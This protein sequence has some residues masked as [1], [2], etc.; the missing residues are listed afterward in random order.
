MNILQAW[1]RRIFYTEVNPVIKLSCDRMLQVDDLEPLPTNTLKDTGNSLSF[2][3]AGKFIL[4]IVRVNRKSSLWGMFFTLFRVIFALSIPVLIKL[5]LTVIVGDE[6]QQSGI[7]NGVVYSFLFAI[8]TIFSGIVTNLCFYWD[9]V[10]FQAHQRLLDSL[11]YQQ[12][13][14]LKATVR[15]KYRSG[16]VI[17]TVGNDVQTI[18]KLG[19]LV[20]DTFYV[21]ILFIGVIVLL[22]N[23]LGLGTFAAV[24]TLL[25]FQPIAQQITKHFIN[26]DNNRAHLRELR[27]NLITQLLSGIRTVKLYDLAG[28]LNTKIR[29]VRDQEVQ[30][31]I[32]W[33]SKA[34]LSIVL[35]GSTTTLICLA[36][37]GT[38]LLLGQ[39]LDPTVLFPS[40]GLLMLLE[41]P[42]AQMPEILNTFSGVKAAGQRVLNFLK[43]DKNPSGLKPLSEPGAAV[44]VSL[45]QV[46]F[47][48]ADQEKLIL[49]GIDLTVKT[50]EAVAIVGSV[51]SGKSVLLRSLLEEDERLSGVIRWEGVSSLQ[52]PRIAY[53]PQEAFIFNA[54]LKENLLMGLEEAGSEEL[55]KRAIEVTAMEADVR[56]LAGGLA[57]EIGERG[58]GLSGGQKQRV[59]LARSVVAQPGLAL[60]DDPF[61]ALD[62]RTE[63]QIV[64]RLL[65]S[66][67]KS[68]TRIVATHRLRFLHRFDKIVFLQEGQIVAQGTLEELLT[69]ADF[70]DFYSEDSIDSSLTPASEKSEAVKENRS[71]ESD[72]NNTLRITEDEDRR[73]GSVGRKIYGDFLQAMA[74]EKNNPKR[75]YIFT[76]LALTVVLAVL[77]P[78]FQNLWFVAWSD[79]QAFEKGSLLRTIADNPGL[80]MLIYAGLGALALVAI[81]T[82][83]ALWN[84]QTAVA[85]GILHN[86][87]LDGVVRAPIRFFDSTMSGVLM[88]RFSRDVFVIENDLRWM[89]ENMVR[90]TFQGLVN[91]ILFILVGPW[92]ILGIVP[93]LWFY[94]RLQKK[95][96]IASREIKRLVQVTQSPLFSHLRE[97][98]DGLLT[99]RTMSQS[100]YFTERFEGRH[101]A[102]QRASRAH[103]LTD[104]WFSVR[105]PILS[106]A[107]SLISAASIFLAARYG[108][109]ST[110]L[111]GVILTYLISFW[112][113]LNWSARTFA[114][115]EGNLTSVER[116][117]H[118]A[119]LPN[120]E[121]LFHKRGS[122]DQLAHSDHF[123]VTNEKDGESCLKRKGASIEFVSTS[124]RYAENLP[125]VLKNVSFSIAP[126]SQV[127]IIGRTGSG[128]S[129]IL[130]SLVGM[131]EVS[132][133][134]ILIDGVPIRALP[135]KTLR[136]LVAVVPQEPFLLNGTIRMNLDPTGQHT[137]ERLMEVVKQVG[138]GDFMTL[139]PDGF[140][141]V[142]SDSGG[143]LSQG[144]RQLLCFARALLK[145]PKIIIMD[146]ATSNV[147]VQTEARIQSQLKAAIDG[148]TV[149]IIAH[150][151][152]TV[153]GCDQIICLSEG[154]LENTT[155]ENGDTYE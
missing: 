15:S 135:L 48:V 78:L 22:L 124:V 91:I 56:Q 107:I 63:E 45:E 25:I 71:S 116:L 103:E 32:N 148:I 110:G 123:A 69:R 36:A 128:K 57:M 138:M 82:Q 120:E 153:L 70:K 33:G 118:L 40:L 3:S 133:G 144:Q 89:F 119:E 81:Y 44:G 12:M 65:F 122:E 39:P 27:L 73:S 8:A 75:L 2:D 83:R 147:D 41:V 150:R 134:D 131:A 21:V 98:F 117:V 74:G 5:I 105:V 24:A 20:N 137:D 51:G 35:F 126:G 112:T 38:R 19:Y 94:Y 67:W 101:N 145:N 37:F 132:S 154:R 92:M 86:E 115:V 9:F 127:G 50:G 102:F 129:T 87:G 146:E 49:S 66:E 10:A 1:F 130:Q 54:T 43:A 108:W 77:I 79:P 58:I 34:A 151:T 114:M 14:E 149:L 90:F 68:I 93:I 55:L 125:D 11:I 88:N 28:L 109:I 155:L 121:T 60:L 4:S 136:K 139:L 23:Y 113:L 80:S 85:A 17:N 104:R 59:S 142:V 96:S 30:Q 100:A 29:D 13:L 97:T 31:Q 95:F 152:S 76:A 46:S 18:S 6:T 62:A 111:A 42:F 61:S 47:S 140:D 84:R 26:F 143:N 53:V 7:S 72:T 16:D 64:E 106:G 52:S 99:I 141:T